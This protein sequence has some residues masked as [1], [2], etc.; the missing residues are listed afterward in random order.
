MLILVKIKFDENLIF[1]AMVLI[2][3]WGKVAHEDGV[4]CSNSSILVYMSQANALESDFS[5]IF[6][7][8]Y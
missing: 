5:S 1:L 4:D 7:H 8:N 2:V 3:F 6:K